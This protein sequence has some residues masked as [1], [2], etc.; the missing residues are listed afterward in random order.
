MDQG[1]L[2]QPLALPWQRSASMNEIE[3]V[4]YF[5]F[6]DSGFADGVFAAGCN[7]AV[8]ESCGVGLAEPVAPCA[9]L[10]QLPRWL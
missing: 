3:T 9:A 2:P 8:D 10:Q 5:V 4:S 6:A 7:A 1:T